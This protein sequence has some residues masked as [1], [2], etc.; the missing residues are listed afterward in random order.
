MF[1]IVGWRSDGCPGTVSFQTVNGIL[2]STY[3]EVTGTV[4]N[5]AR[6]RINESRRI[7][8]LDAFCQLEFGIVVG[9][10]APAF[11]VD[12]L[13]LVRTRIRVPVLACT[14]PGHNT[15]VTP[16]LVDHDFQLKPKFGLLPVVCQ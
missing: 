7:Q 4:V 8:S 13:R 10:L 5:P 6:G 9:D 3:A 1:R 12:N 15:R 2:K 16:E 11:V 14:H